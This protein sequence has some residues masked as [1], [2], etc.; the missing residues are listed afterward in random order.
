MIRLT[1]L[2]N[3]RLYLVDPTD[4][5]R[6]GTWSNGVHYIR[7]RDERCEVSVKETPE[8]VQEMRLLWWQRQLALDPKRPIWLE[9]S[10]GNPRFVFGV[11]H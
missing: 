6:M 2:N 3:T 8:I 7:V 5:V 9:W 11:L 1:P 4:I 10:D